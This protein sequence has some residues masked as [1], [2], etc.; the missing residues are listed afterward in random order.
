MPTSPKTTAI[1]DN[2]R[3]CLRSR[4]Q[5]SLQ[6]ERTPWNICQQSPLGQDRSKPFLLFPFLPCCSCQTYRRQS[7]DPKDSISLCVCVQVLISRAMPPH[8]YRL[9]WTWINISPQATSLAKYTS[10]PSPQR[11]PYLC[12]VL[13][14]YIY[15]PMFRSG[16][17]WPAPAWQ[18]SQSGCLSLQPYT[19]CWD[20]VHPLIAVHEKVLSLNVY[21][22]CGSI[23][24]LSDH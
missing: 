17:L 10:S 6:Q 8:L 4:Y 3:T 16:I 18:H 22:L 2:N 21:I 12:L 13:A 7:H 19:A 24:G 5:E 9:A 23:R 20:L 1:R 11:L 15:V 14:W